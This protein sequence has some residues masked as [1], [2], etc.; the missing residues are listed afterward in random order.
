MK[1]IEIDELVILYEN[2]EKGMLIKWTGISKEMDPSA[3]LIPIMNSLLEEASG[4]LILDFYDLEYIN[5]ASVVP[6]I[7]FVKAADERKIYT[8]IQYNPQLSWQKSMFKAFT[9]LTKIL[10]Y[11]SIKEI[12]K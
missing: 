5:S 2:N 6:I 1:Q 11:L 12:R 8:E 3:K 7:T 10:K 9:A 4:N